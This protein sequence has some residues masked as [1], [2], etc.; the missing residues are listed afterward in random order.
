MSMRVTRIA[1][2]LAGIVAVGAV[3]SAT[4]APGALG[5]SI[6]TVP[7]ELSFDGS[8]TYYVHYSFDDTAKGG[9]T[10]DTTATL[11]LSWKDRNSFGDYQAIPRPAASGAIAIGVVSGPGTFKVKGT[12]TA[13]DNCSIAVHP[14][15]NGDLKA[16][17]DASGLSYSV[18]AEGQNGDKDVFTWHSPFKLDTSVHCD[19]TNDQ[20]DAGF[21]GGAMKIFNE[22]VASAITAKLERDDSAVI[23]GNTFTGTVGE[24]ALAG[25]KGDCTADAQALFPGPKASCTQTLSWTGTVKLKGHPNPMAPG[26]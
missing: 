2:R 14:S 20:S 24:S 7:V 1:R 3:A 4:L 5:G 17:H 10:S 25:S 21:A 18:P 15:C 23:S 9:C 6:Y 8:G 22:S 12:E 19:G 16:G 13:G 11:T 26:Q